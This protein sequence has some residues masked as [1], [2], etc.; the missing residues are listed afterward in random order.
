MTR[1]DRTRRAAV[2]LAGGFAILAIAGCGGGA[3]FKDRPRPPVPIQLTGVITDK[4]VS[5]EPRRVGAGPVIINIQ[6]QTTRSHTVTVEG[7]PHNTVE[8]TAP[9]N[10]LD[11]GQIQQTLDPGTYTVKAGSDQASTNEIKPT[12]LEIGPAR[13]SSS[14]T[15]LLP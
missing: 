12:T 4:A 9:I 14:D 1:V 3:E 6:N 13:K 2:L 7:G 5:V 8:Q 15:V 10:P 11:T